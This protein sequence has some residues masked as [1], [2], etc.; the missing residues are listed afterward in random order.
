[1]FARDVRKPN[2]SNVTTHMIDRVT[3]TGRICSRVRLCYRQVVSRTKGDGRATRLSSNEED[4]SI[5]SGDTELT[6][7]RR[8]GK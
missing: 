6:I 5:T 3:K 1:M 2:Y 8:I 7:H 4:R